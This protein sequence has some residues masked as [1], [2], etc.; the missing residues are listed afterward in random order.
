M[1]DADVGIVGGGLAGSVAAAMLGRAGISCILVD[2]HEMYPADF[3]C[4]KIDRP[5]LELLAKTGLL[6]DI[7]PSS[8]LTSQMWIARYGWLLASRADC[9]VGI[10][11]E[12]IVNAARRAIPERTLRITAQAEAIS[13]SATEQIISTSGG[14][15]F[16][17]RLAVLATGLNN[18]LRNSLG[19]SRDEISKCHSVSIGF[20]A[21]PGD[22]A[23]FRFPA[24][25]YFSECSD[26]RV[27]Y[28]TFFPIK[29]KMRV[30]LFVYREMR[31]PWIK[32][33]QGAPEA[34]LLSCLPGLGRFVGQLKVAGEIQTRPVDLYVTQGCRQAGVVLV[35]DAFSTSCPA[36]G[37]GTSKVFT[38]VER[39]CN[40]HIPR[41]LS[42]PGM[43]A[44]KIG[45]F[46][47]DPVKVASDAASASRAYYVRSLAIDDRLPWRIRRLGWCLK[48]VASRIWQLSPGY[49]GLEGD[50]SSRL[51]SATEAVA[52]ASRQ[53]PPIRSS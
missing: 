1:L 27:G 12:D 23:H 24:L 26:S 32:E 17:V 48:D 14:R 39:L 40:V 34:T 46:Y 43:E 16:S 47:D 11:Y 15:T 49:P 41:W 10:L 20:D 9:Q 5:Q 33:F 37:T 3:R 36:A 52:P 29:G 18:R 45:S 4:E 28:I 51:G 8:T 22:Q 21:S 50:L 44:A 7:L 31:D 42:S 53:T 30:N 13:T 25:T 2:P 19:I 35:G 38:D 6:P